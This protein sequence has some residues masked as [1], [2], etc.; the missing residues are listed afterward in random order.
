MGRPGDTE[1]VLAGAR[2]AGLDLD[3][4]NFVM[5]PELPNISSTAAR[6][7]LAQKDMPALKRLLHPR[8]AAWCLEN[9]YPASYS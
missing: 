5:G 1:R 4:G 7:A 9:G 2:D 6:A 8:V 3:D